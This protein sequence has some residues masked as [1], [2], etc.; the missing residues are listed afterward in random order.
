MFSQNGPFSNKL[1]IK[2]NIWKT[3]EDLDG[4]EELSTYLYGATVRIINKHIQVDIRCHYDNVTFYG[5][6]KQK[7]KGGSIPSTLSKMTEFVKDRR[8]NVG[9][10]MLVK[11]KFT[12]ETLNGVGIKIDMQNGVGYRP[13]PTTHGEL[14]T[15]LQILTDATNANTSKLD[16]LMTL[17]QFANDEGDFGE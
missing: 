5:L 7:T 17:V 12:C 6:K 10:K 14:I 11:R 2:K 1:S 15:M 3:S 4:N 13:V 16:E 8:I 9:S